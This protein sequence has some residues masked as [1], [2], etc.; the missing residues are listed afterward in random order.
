VE[1]ALLE[2]MLVGWRRQ[3][4]ARRLGPSIIG[5]RERVVRRFVEFT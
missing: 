2:E 4:L 3:Q 5:S 1:A